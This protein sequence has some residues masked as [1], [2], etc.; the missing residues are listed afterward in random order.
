MN[1]AT[2]S[3][4]HE[5]DVTVEGVASKPKRKWCENEQKCTRNKLNQVKGNLFRKISK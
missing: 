3:G 5:S 4:R 2:G 1:M